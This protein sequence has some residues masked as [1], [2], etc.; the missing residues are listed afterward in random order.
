[1]LCQKEPVVYTALLFGYK[2]S[3]WIGSAII[4]YSPSPGQSIVKRLIMRTSFYGQRIAGAWYTTQYLYGGYSYFDNMKEF[5]SNNGLRNRSSA[6]PADKIH[7]ENIG[8]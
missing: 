7:Y 1:M 4:V 3:T 6:I 2:N 5:F 8:V